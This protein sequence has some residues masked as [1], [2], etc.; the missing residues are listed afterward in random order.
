MSVSKAAERRLAQGRTRG[1]ADCVE[2]RP[3][4]AASVPASSPAGTSPSTNTQLSRIISP[5]QLA[6]ILGVSASTLWRMVSRH[7]LPNPIQISRGRVGWPE[8][9][10]VAWLALRKEVR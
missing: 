6:G 8:S 10:M 2:A 9:E 7:D 3:M 5:R 1:A 4:L